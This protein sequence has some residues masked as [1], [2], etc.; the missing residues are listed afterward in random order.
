MPTG[1]NNSSKLKGKILTYLP[2]FTL[3]QSRCKLEIAG[4]RLVL[5]QYCVG[6]LP[7]NLGFGQG[8][9]LESGQIEANALYFK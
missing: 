7:L 4:K 3:Y 9:G 8:V 6:Y 5:N 1:V 2:S